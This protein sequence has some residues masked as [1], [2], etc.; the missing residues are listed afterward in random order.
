KANSSMAVSTSKTPTV[1]GE[2]VTFTAIVSAVSPGQGTPSGTV[3]FLIDGSVPTGGGGIN[4]SSGKATFTISNLP[5]GGHT[6]D[7]NYGGDASFTNSSGSLVGGQTVNLANTSV[8]VSS[9]LNPSVFGQPVTFNATVTPVAPGSGTPTGNVNFIVDGSSRGIVGLNASGIATITISNLSASSTAHNAVAS[10]LGNSSSNSG[11]GSL[12]GGQ[13]VTKASTPT[14][15]PS[16]VTPS[17][18]SQPVTFTATVTVTPP[19]GNTPA[20]TVDFV[21]DG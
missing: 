10:Y 13:A 8:A 18:F 2:K 17:P 4:L 1:F 15:V 9:S 14:T 6:V 19:G 12:A 11:S 5:T 21:I 7:V 20:G 3:D 16:S